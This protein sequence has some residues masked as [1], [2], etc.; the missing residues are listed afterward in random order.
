[1]NI[2]EFSTEVQYDSESDEYLLT[3]PPELLEEMQ[4]VEG[5]V[6]EWEYHDYNGLPGLRLHK[7]GE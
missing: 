7:V 3:L 6:L 2:N 5:D 1:M 4:W